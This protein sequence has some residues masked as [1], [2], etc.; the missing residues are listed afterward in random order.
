MVGEINSKICLFD[1]CNWDFN[2]DGVHEV[3]STNRTEGRKFDAAFVPSGDEL[4]LISGT[5]MNNEGAD[6]PKQQQSQLPETSGL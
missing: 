1:S 5:V 4:G 2:C 3:T 6:S